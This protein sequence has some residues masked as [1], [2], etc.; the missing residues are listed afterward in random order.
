MEKKII[1]RVTDKTYRMITRV[2]KETGLNR[3]DILRLA[4]TYYLKAR[5]STNDERIWP[6]PKGS[7]RNKK[8]S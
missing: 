2:S 7:I 6:S 4:I 1:T 5:E 8:N 3:S